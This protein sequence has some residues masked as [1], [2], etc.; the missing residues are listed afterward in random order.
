M[1]WVLGRLQA[2][3]LSVHRP[4]ALEFFAFVRGVPGPGCS[5]VHSVF[6]GLL[7]PFWSI[8]GTNKDT[9]VTTSVFVRALKYLLTLIVPHEGQF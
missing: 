3:V 6:I 9:D 8:L 2:D 1:V 5:L 7:S 4:E